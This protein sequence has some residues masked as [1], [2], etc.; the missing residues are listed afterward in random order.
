MTNVHSTAVVA[1]GAKIPASAKIGAYCGLE[2]VDDPH[3]EHRAGLT[4]GDFA[5]GKRPPDLELPCAIMDQKFK[6]G[7]PLT[8][9]D[10]KSCNFVVKEQ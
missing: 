8:L 3:F 10:L 9:D 2:Q 6:L 5:V 7:Q 1:P 4:V